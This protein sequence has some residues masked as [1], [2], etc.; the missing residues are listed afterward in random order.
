[1]QNRIFSSFKWPLL[2]IFLVTQAC[3]AQ[4]EGSI[5]GKVTM[6]QGWKPVVYL[7]HP[8][9]FSEVASDYLGEVV[10]SAQVASDGTLAFHYVP[11]VAG[12]DLYF[13]TM[14][15][16]GSRFAT[17][18][19]DSDPASA[20]YM[21]VVID[22]T[23]PIHFTAASSTFQQSFT[24]ESPLSD[25]MALLSLSDIRRTALRAYLTQQAQR[26]DNDTLLLEHEK[27]FLGYA[28]SL[29][30]F[31]DST[32]S[33]YSAMVA[34]RWISI[35]GDYERFPEFIYR[36]CKKWSS[37]SPDHPLVAGLCQ[38]TKAGV[39]PVM[40]GDVLPDYKLP[41]VD[42]DT[43]SVKQLLGKKLTIVD[44]WASWC[45]P[46]RK[47]NRTV[48]VPLWDQYKTKGLQII[49]YSIDIDKNAWQNAI[50]K[51]GAAWTHA[52]HLTGDET[53][54][55]QTLRI[56]TIP[57]N[58]ILDEAGKVVAKNVYGEDLQKLVMAYLEK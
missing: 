3:Q 40:I 4:P 2:V 10:D 31:A 55:L 25:N 39:L 36:Q 7:V 16:E 44:I 9:Q 1:M 13:L 27:E 53:P 56:T 23:H 57:A 14:Q 45:A 41:M 5:H 8:R 20:N 11:K 29:I 48:L 46:C 43:L 51:D 12:A 35:A 6:E 26:E 21:P 37:T 15:R 19:D 34:I 47:E 58:Y 49:G 52:S 42:G 50:L 54:F 33:M 24:L 30:Q 22:A 32:S 18:L 17:H 38:A 28:N